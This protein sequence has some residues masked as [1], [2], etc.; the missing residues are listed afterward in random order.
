M[1]SIVSIALKIQACVDYINKLDLR[2]KYLCLGFLLAFVTMFV[3]S[4]S[5]SS[6]QSQSLV[7]TEPVR[8]DLKDIETTI[9]GF[10]T[11]VDKLSLPT[12]KESYESAKNIVESAQDNDSPFMCLDKEFCE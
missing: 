12:K 2:V 5:C 9:E 10:E 11:A 8:N 6:S 4:K 7:Q 3:A 1:S